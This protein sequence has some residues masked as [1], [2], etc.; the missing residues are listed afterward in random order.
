MTS[1]ETPPPDSN[2]SEPAPPAETKRAKAKRRQRH[3]S[4]ALAASVVTLSAWYG[5]IRL[6]M[7]AETGSA[8][9]GQI[10]DQMARPV[11]LVNGRNCQSRTPSLSRTGSFV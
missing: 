2:A 3:W 1:A 10:G 5:S 8:L 4:W 9:P 7:G 6:P 11:P